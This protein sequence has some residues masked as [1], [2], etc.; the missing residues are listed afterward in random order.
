MSQE[1]GTASQAHD[2]LGS[3][4]A[5]RGSSSPGDV[6]Q[7]PGNFWL[8]HLQGKGAPGIWWAEARDAA[9]HPTTHG[10]ATPP[11]PHQRM[12]CL[13]HQQR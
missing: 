2:L 3:R 12:S 7:C 4:E 13:K 1:P 9:K 6:W 5:R 10:T 11:V 8:S